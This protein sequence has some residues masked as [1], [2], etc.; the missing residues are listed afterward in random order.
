MDYD[1]IFTVCIRSYTYNHARYLKNTMDGF[2]KQE[3]NFPFVAIIID[4]AS[5]DNAAQ[6]LTNYFNSSFDT[7]NSS[8]AYRAEEEYGTVLFAQHLTNKNCYFA[9]VLL[10]ENHYRQRKSKG[11]YLSHWRENSEFIAICEGDD[12]W[13]DPHKLQKQVDILNEDP[14]L[15]AVV[16]NSMIVDSEGKTLSNCMENIVP[17]NRDGRYSLHDY[18]KNVHHY[19]TATVLY[20]NNHYS[21]VRKMIRHT[22][23]KYLGD[24]TLWAILHSFGDFYYL[25]AV[26][27]A[28]R[29]NPASLTHTVDRVE[30]AKAN[31]TICRS[32]SEVLPPEYSQYLKEA[33]WMYFSVFMAYRKEKKWLKM[34]SSLFVCFFKYPVYTLQRLIHL[35]QGIEK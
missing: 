30:R 35:A 9:I 13:I 2:V 34:I 6:I 4:D 3:T 24:W 7:G 28:Y 22:K 15:M 10:K 33:G 32:L 29:I 11:Q 19:P 16:T 31:I 12:Y 26:T 18:L 21:E 25:N 23:N 27:S 14:E 17:G 1:L 20:R 8:V 5:T